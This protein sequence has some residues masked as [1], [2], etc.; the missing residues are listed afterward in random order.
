MENIEIIQNSIDYIEE[1]LKSELTVE[2][3]ADNSG[4][5]LFH[6]YR[7]FQSEVGMPVMQYILLRKLKNAIYEISCGKKAID[8]ALDYG[9]ETYAGF[10]KAFKREFG[11]APTQYLKKHTVKKPHKVILKQEEH[12]MISHKKIRK[13]LTNWNLT[14]ASILDIYHEGSGIKLENAWYI[15]ENLVFKADK[16]LIRLKNHIKI[17][18][19]LSKAG[20]DAAAPMKTCSGNDYVIDGDIYFCL[21]NRLQGEGIKSDNCYKGNFETKMQY[22]G[23]TIGQ[24]H[25]ILKKFDEEILLDEPSLYETIKN[26]AIPEIKK[27]MTFPNSFYDDY[28]ETFGRLYPDLPRHIIHRDPNPSNIIMRDGKITGFIDFELSE[29]NIRIFD[30]CYASTAILSESFDKNDFHKLQKWIII[31]KNIIDGYDSICKLSHKEKQA[32]PYVIFSIQMI[33]VAYFSNMDKYAELAEVN[34]KML[35]WLYDN[36]GLLNLI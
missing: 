21:A 20:F 18:K 23:E 5:S 35:K 33:C 34:Q 14:D 6:Y 13:I 31:Y 30:P 11:V 8:I 15:N 27:Y 19:A 36:K 2:E 22:L 29:R 4:F 17:S 16:S 32:I 25:L 12:I 9:F 24:L 1:N 28:L 3:L 26:W 10:F 7:I